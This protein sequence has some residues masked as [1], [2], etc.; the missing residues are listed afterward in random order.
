MPV[1]ST[2]GGVDPTPDKGLAEARVAWQEAILASAIQPLVT[3]AYN[4]VEAQEDELAALYAP[5]MKEA[6]QRI[7]SQDQ[8]LGSVVSDLLARPRTAISTQAAA[9]QDISTTVVEDEQGIPIDVVVEGPAEGGLP[10]FPTVEL[11]SEEVIKGAPGPTPPPGGIVVGGVVIT[12][13]TH[14]EYFR[15]APGMPFPVPGVPV[16][17]IPELPAGVVPPPPPVAPAAPVGPGIGIHG[18]A[19]GLPGGPMAP[20]P[21]PP[22]EPGPIFVP[23]PGVP[24]PINITIP[25]LPPIVI[26]PPPPPGV[27][28]PTPTPP[29]PPES[30]PGAETPIAAPGMPPARPI[31]AP[32]LA[33]PHFP[34]VCGWD[35]GERQLCFT[36]ESYLGPFGQIG[37]AIEQLLDKTADAFSTAYT[38][39]Y[40]AVGSIPV[41]G[42]AFQAVLD[43]LPADQLLATLKAMRDV[44]RAEKPVRGTLLVG[45]WGARALLRLA[46]NATLGWE[47][48]P[49]LLLS[50]HYEMPQL[51]AIIDYLIEYTCPVRAPSAAEVQQLYLADV[52]DQVHADC[53]SRLQGQSPKLLA[54]NTYAARARPTDLTLVADWRRF[55][56]QPAEI[57]RLLRA[58]GWLNA[59]EREKLIRSADYLPP[60]S[61]LISFAVRDVYSPKKIGRAEMVAEYQEQGDLKDWFASQGIGP[62]QIARRNGEM[63]SGDVG[64]AYWLAHYH[65][66]SPTQVFEMLHR[67][68]PGRV[69]RYKFRSAGG[70]EVTPAPVLI[71][72]V[73]SLLKED[74]YNPAWRDRLAAISY[75][76][77]TRVDVRRVYASGGFGVP[78]GSSGFAPAM[79]GDLEATGEAEKELVAVN[80]DAGY[81]HA[82]AVRLAY[83]AAKQ[84]TETALAPE[85]KKQARLACAT[86]QAGGIGRD[87]ALAAFRRAT[88]SDERAAAMLDSC[89]MERHL[90]EL[91]AGIAAVRKGYLRGEFSDITVRDSLGLL[92]VSQERQTE[93][94]RLWRIEREA[95]GKQV[96]ASVMCDWHSKGLISIPEMRQRL[97]RIGYSA[98]DTER[99]IAHC[100][101]GILGREAK[102]RE[103]RIKA[104]IRD[105]EKRRKLLEK[106]QALSEKVEDKR[107]TQFLAARSEKHLIDW[108]IAGEVTEADARRTLLLKGWVPEDIDRWLKVTV[109]AARKKAQGGGKEQGGE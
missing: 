44:P 65:N 12:P 43:M 59:T 16:P 19:G 70:A 85:R 106:R 99:V 81:V 90:K 91:R 107:L 49:Q 46:E 63:I 47:L 86:Y 11:P 89:D 98:D 92:G 32:G 23:I 54:L 104:E 74:D 37:A 55:A 26:Q 2:F 80:E 38:L 4:T 94:F 76:N 48:G 72:D 97:L 71:D 102:E 64:E 25:G 56:G 35:A 109:G 14:P 3:T 66:V 95:Q 29:P 22:P 39:L 15:V 9:I 51:R 57:H 87:K 30:K 77:L 69:G 68:R 108:L 101:L 82:D 24:S 10:E 60:P 31:L 79:G 13:E 34:S 62:V 21:E 52:I 103:A 78:R 36:I 75:R 7:A 53:L 50:L 8:E 5:Q 41:A 27:A 88:D 17:A 33:I 67:L 45:L 20:I 40:K 84:Y 18:P 105:Q 73:R 6:G 83:F 100:R 1:Y 42:A 28:P 61:D 96:A 93:F 58:N